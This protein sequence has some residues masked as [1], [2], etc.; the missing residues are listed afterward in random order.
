MIFTEKAQR[1][2]FKKYVE[3]PYLW[4]ELPADCNAFFML[5]IFNIDNILSISFSKSSDNSY[6]IR[7]MLIL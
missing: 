7:F 3:M 4:E 2:I 5:S 6:R 1:L